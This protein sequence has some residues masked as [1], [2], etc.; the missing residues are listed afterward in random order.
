[1]ALAQRIDGRVRNLREPLL[2]V[3]PKRTRQSRQKRRR[4]VIA[5]APQRFLTL[6][7]ERVEKYTEL[8]FGPSEGRH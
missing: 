8:I 3:I 2:A 4:C 5:H 1:M 6:L 7:Y